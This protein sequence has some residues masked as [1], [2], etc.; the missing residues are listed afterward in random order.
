[1]GNGPQK[2]RWTGTQGAATQGAVSHRPIDDAPEAPSKDGPV[3]HTPHGLPISS[4]DYERLK[5][6][7]RFQKPSA[8]SIGHQDSSVTSDREE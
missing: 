4:E 5:T 2:T 3:K 8:S 6:R 1:M 7:A